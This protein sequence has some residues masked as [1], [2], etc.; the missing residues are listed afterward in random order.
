MKMGA[1]AGG[2]GGI[3][4]SNYFQ[5]SCEV[6]DAGIGVACTRLPLKAGGAPGLA[7]DI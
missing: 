5:D 2:E 6:T 1:P 4:S 3:P 7:E